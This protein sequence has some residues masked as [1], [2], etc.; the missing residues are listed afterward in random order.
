MTTLAFE[1]LSPAERLALIGE[2][3]DSIDAESV[4]LTPAQATELDFR[5]AAADADLDEPINWETIRAEMAGKK[6]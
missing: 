3:W 2:I 1:H 6:R 5:L 4:P